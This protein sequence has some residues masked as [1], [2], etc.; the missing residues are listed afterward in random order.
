MFPFK[1]VDWESKRRKSQWL[2]RRQKEEASHSWGRRSEKE[3]GAEIRGHK[4]IQK[5]QAF[6]SIHQQQIVSFCLQAELNEVVPSQCLCSESIHGRNS[7][8]EELAAM[9]Q[10][11]WQKQCLAPNSLL[12]S[13]LFS[14]FERNVESPLPVFYKFLLVG[15]FP[16]STALSSAGELR[17]T[18]CALVLLMLG[19]KCRLILRGG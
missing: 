3:P 6:R 4:C 1:G 7:C 19:A 18:L 2:S 13:V 8:V 10:E 12:E 15:L 17:H 16:G 9:L 5:I 14:I 11:H